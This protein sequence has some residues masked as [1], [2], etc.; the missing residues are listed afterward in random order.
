M[1][2]GPVNPADVA[3][4]HIHTAGV[5]VFAAVF[6]MV[7]IVIARK[8]VYAV[9]ALILLDPFAY[10]QAIGPTTLTLSKIAL[11]AAIAG[12][13]VRKTSLVALRKAPVT[14]LAVAVL[15]VAAATALSIA[16]AA[17]VVPAIRETLKWMEY[18]LI[19]SVCAVAFY[20]DPDQLPIR[21]AVLLVTAAVVA[22]SLPELVVGA[23]SGIMLARTEVPRI[24]GPLEG[25]N[26]LAAYLGLML[27][28]MLAYTLLRGRRW[29]EIFVIVGG[30]LTTLA[31]F[32]R[33]GLVALAIAL[34]LV[35]LLCARSSLA[36]A[37][38]GAAALAVL[39]GAAVSWRLVAGGI[40]LVTAGPHHHV[41][42]R[43]GLGTR[44]DLWQAAIQLWRAHPVWGIGAGNYELE[45]GKVLGAPIKTHTNSFYLQSLVEGGPLLLCAGL[46]LIYSSVSAFVRRA[47]TPLAVAALAASAALAVH[48]ILDLLVFYP[49]VGMEWMILLGL[50]AAEAAISSGVKNHSLVSESNSNPSPTG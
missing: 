18:A 39:A 38:Y 19:L 4:P 10:Y 17:H 14:S 12:L 16:H 48:F 40:G 30:V 33:G 5:V 13:F 23:H 41:E 34:L 15:L 43:G 11:A 1:Q 2:F 28:L 6:A 35:A 25:P 31:T 44:R 47:Q 26:Q 22:L 45:V 32:S 9:V 42:I 20:E 46:F 27:P 24:A 7:A 36:R 37:F 8:P 29:L 21:W 50:A 3:A 49:K